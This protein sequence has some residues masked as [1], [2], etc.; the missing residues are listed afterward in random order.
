MIP[1]SILDLAPV[2]EGSD[3]G[4]ALANTIDLARH[5]ERL[6]YRLVDHRMELYGVSL[7]RK[8][9]EPLTQATAPQGGEA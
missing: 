5:A 4:Q 3:V 6:G 1:Q 7:D 2:P 8:T 9:A